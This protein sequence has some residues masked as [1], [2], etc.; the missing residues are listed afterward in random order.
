MTVIDQPGIYDLTLAEYLAD[1]CAEPSISSSG[2]RTIENECPLVYW[3]DS[4][5]NPNRE[6]STTTAFEFGRATHDWLLQKDRFLEFNHVLSDSCDL[7]TKAGKAERDEA[8]EAGKTVIK[9]EE[10]E[11][12][13][14]MRQ[15]VLDH[16][17]AGAAFENGKAEQTLVWKDPETGVWLRCRP[18]YLPAPMDW[19]PDYKTAVSA[20]PQEFQRA[21]WNH[22]YHMQAAHIME[23]ILR[24]TGHEP[25]NFFFVVQEKRPPYIV[26]V[27]ALDRIA[28]EWGATQNRRAIRIFAGCLERDHWPGYSSRVEQIGLPGFAEH[29]LQARHEAGEFTNHEEDT[30]A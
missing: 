30:A 18:D 6:R 5:L 2:L 7:R 20:K 10:F 8:L 27:I 25:R 23:G 17:Y 26:S 4:P 3:H 1:P 28:L 15:A 11:A 16:E 12:V 9:A 19:I 21:V 22:G 29:Q 24:V 14:A 13:K